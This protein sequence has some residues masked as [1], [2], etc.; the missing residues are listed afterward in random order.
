M[1]NICTLSPAYQLIDDSWSQSMLHRAP[2][3]FV[4]ENDNKAVHNSKCIGS[5]TYQLMLLITVPVCLQE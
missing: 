2:L 3:I 4:S 1:P 5:D